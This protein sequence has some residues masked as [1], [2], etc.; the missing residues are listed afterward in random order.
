LLDAKYLSSASLGKILLRNYRKAFSSWNYQHDEK[1]V[2]VS[3]LKLEFLDRTHFMKQ[4]LFCTLGTLIFSGISM[5]ALIAPAIAAPQ[6]PLL[7]AQN[8]CISSFYRVKTQDKGRLNVRANP[9]MDAKIVGKL[10]YGT[11]VV[12]N[13][14]HRSGEWA[15][16]TAPKGMP[17]GWVAMRYLEQVPMGGSLP[18]GV[19]R[20]RTLDGD[21]LNVRAQPSL[22]G[23]IIGKLPNGSR[24]SF[25]AN[26]GYWT[27]VSTKGVT[28][29]V[30]NQY[31]VC[32]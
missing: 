14:V 12:V 4:T 2:P 22:N 24:V 23:K 10:P 30:A 1:R 9:G 26:E 32:D 7:L 8:Q 18:N 28:G 16:I 15:E 31:L 25:I 3:T 19:M 21:R 17:S 5:P 13:L 20:V 27:K 29:Y 6:K 11:D